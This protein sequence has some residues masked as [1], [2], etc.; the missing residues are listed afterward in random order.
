MTLGV[1]HLRLISGLTAVGLCAGSAALV[2][3]D[4]KPQSAP[5][6]P[7]VPGVTKDSAALPST[8]PPSCGSVDVGGARA[9]SAP[10]P[11]YS[12]LSQAAQQA[13]QRIRSTRARGS[14]LQ[15]ILATL[16]AS[17]RQ[18]VVAYLRASGGGAGRSRC[19]GGASTSPAAPGITASVGDGGSATPVTISYVS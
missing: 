14:Q 8:L 2:L 11:A 16:S 10:P 5:L 3:G 4:P 7:P 1:G 9:G 18:M 15:Q 13:V 19:A 6:H 12:Q 17:D